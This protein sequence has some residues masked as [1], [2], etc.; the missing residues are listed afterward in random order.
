MR[1]CKQRANCTGGLRNQEICITQVHSQQCEG[2]LSG[3]IHDRPFFFTLYDHLTCFVTVDST[4]RQ[5]QTA[6][7]LSPRFV[8]GSS[9]HNHGSGQETQES[10][11]KWAYQAPPIGELFKVCTC[12]VVSLFSFSLFYPVIT[13]QGPLA[14]QEGPTKHFLAKVKNTSSRIGIFKVVFLSGK[15]VNVCMLDSINV[16]KTSSMSRQASCRKDASIMAKSPLTLHPAS[17]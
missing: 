3:K 8:R 16:G 15:S 7:D 14:A 12:F 4:F 5:I 9:L 6:F 10:H 1:Q 2:E 11:E 17:Y 13:E